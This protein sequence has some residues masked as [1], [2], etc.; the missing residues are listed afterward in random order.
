MTQT[1]TSP[2]VTRGY[3]FLEKFLAEQRCRKANQL[4]PSS[5]R[6]GRILDVGCGS[7]PLFL[8]NTSFSKKYALDKMISANQKQTAEQGII[9]AH[10][11]FEL[12]ESLPFEDNFFDVVTMLAVFEHIKPE[13]LGRLL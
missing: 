5:A 7:Y 10:C 4:I 13:I 9:F 11:D 6:S 12:Q 2:N 1:L 8:L 3:G